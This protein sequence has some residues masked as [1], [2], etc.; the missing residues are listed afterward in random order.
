MTA[1]NA[2][3]MENAGPDAETVTEQLWQR[4]YIGKG[5]A[6]VV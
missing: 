2:S 5:T 3:H 1:I 6:S 4:K